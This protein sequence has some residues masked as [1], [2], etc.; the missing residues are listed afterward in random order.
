MLSDYYKKIIDRKRDKIKNGVGVVF[1]SRCKHGE[2]SMPGFRLG[3]NPMTAFE[4]MLEMMKGISF[5]CHDSR[6]LFYAIDKGNQI[7]VD[8]FEERVKKLDP[9]NYR[10]IL[11]TYKHT[12]PY[13]AYIAIDNG[14]NN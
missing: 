10:M 9:K 1:Q 8:Q 12:S 5:T 13:H 2:K 7:S 3:M 11:H 4:C 14:P 6:G